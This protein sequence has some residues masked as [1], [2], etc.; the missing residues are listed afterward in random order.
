MTFHTP[1]KVSFIQIKIEYINIEH[2][3]DLNCFGITFNKN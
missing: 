2:V 1:K 3:S